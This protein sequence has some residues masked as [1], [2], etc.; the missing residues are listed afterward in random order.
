MD[1]HNKYKFV[2]ESARNFLKDIIANH[3]MDTSILKAHMQHEQKFDDLLDANHRLIRSLTNRNMM[4]SVIGFDKKEKEMRLILF[5]YNPNKILTAY[6][7]ADELLGKFKSKF[8]LQ[9]V[10]VKEVYG[11]NF[12][13]V[14]FPA[15]ILWHLLE[16]KMISI[17]L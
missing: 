15:V 5:G 11:V 1:K 12:Q 13:R 3:N 8:N 4:D 9:N 16:I 14:S 2:F 10:R 17:V 6:K 7:N